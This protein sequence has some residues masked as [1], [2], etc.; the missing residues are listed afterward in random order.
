MENIISTNNMNT[1]SLSNLTKSQLISLLIKQNLEI[2]QLLQQNMQQQPIPTQITEKPIPAP[3]KSVKQMV[4]DYEENVEFRDDYK[5]TPKP[6]TKKPVPLLRTKIEEKAQAMK[7]YTIVNRGDWLGSLENIKGRNKNAKIYVRRSTTLHNLLFC[8]HTLCMNYVT[9]TFLLAS[10]SVRSKQLF[11]FVQGQGQK[12][13]QKHTTKNFVEF[14][15]HSPLLTMVTQSL[16]KSTL[17]T[18]KI[19]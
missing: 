8:A 14:H 1:R 19:P 12:S 13:K 15:N 10:S 16:M 11:C 18:T 17:K 6:K 4:Q 9:N 7:G 5:P 2:K 3:R